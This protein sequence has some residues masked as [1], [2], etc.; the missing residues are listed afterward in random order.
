MSFKATGRLTFLVGAVIVKFGYGVDPDFLV[1]VLLASRLFLRCP[2]NSPAPFPLLLY[3]PPTK[4]LVRV[5]VVV[6]VANEFLNRWRLI[7]KARL[8]PSNVL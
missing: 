3:P 6:S 1:V 5:V 2:C 7:R 8:A 4:S